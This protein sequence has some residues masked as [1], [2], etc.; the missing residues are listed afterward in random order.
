MIFPRD[1]DAE[2]VIKEIET[3]L[4]LQHKNTNR[5]SN[6]ELVEYINELSLMLMYNSELA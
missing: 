5:I 1:P 3:I 6:Y 4:N 2:I